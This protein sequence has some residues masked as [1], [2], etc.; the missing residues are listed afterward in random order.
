[1]INIYSSLSR[2]YTSLLKVEKN[3]NKNKRR[4]NLGQDR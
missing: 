3:N 1:M 2:D 4:L